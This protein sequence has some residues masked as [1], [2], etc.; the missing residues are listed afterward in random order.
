MTSVGSDIWI[1][2]GLLYPG[3]H[4]QLWALVIGPKQNHPDF[5]NSSKSV[6]LKKW[7]AWFSTLQE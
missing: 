4:K 7:M 3:P 1:T 2:S 6:Y 5:G